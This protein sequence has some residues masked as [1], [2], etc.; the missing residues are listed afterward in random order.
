M[1]ILEQV[2]PSFKKKKKKKRGKIPQQN[3]FNI[4]DITCIMERR[5]FCVALFS[6]GRL[7]LPL[8]ISIVLRFLNGLCVIYEQMMSLNVHEFYLYSHSHSPNLFLYCDYTSLFI[9]LSH[10]L[11]LS[12]SYPLFGI[13]GI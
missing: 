2:S 10:S 3:D 12:L 11:S 13:M 7:T 4:R 8:I 6:L 9:H 1:S 5:V